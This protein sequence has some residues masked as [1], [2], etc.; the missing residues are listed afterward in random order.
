MS[1]STKV[2]V[3]VQITTVVIDLTGLA[4]PKTLMTADDKSVGLTRVQH[5]VYDVI[6]HQNIIK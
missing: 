5:N 3:V 4:Q 6:L 1:V 2:D